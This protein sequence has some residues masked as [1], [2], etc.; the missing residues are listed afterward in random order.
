MWMLEGPS[1]IARAE[2]RTLAT[3]DH[4]IRHGAHLL[5]RD[6]AAFELPDAPR[7]VVGDA[8]Q[9]GLTP[10]GF[11][12][13]GQRAD[14]QQQLQQPVFDCGRTPQRAHG[15]TRV[16]ALVLERQPVERATRDLAV[17]T[18]LAA[19]YAQADAA[20]ELAIS[21]RTVS[22]T[23]W[24]SPASRSAMALPIPRLAPVTNATGIGRAR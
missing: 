7:H 3:S 4:A 2:L 6:L 23:S 1:V 13:L 24:P 14:R 15:G 11:Q 17:V 21:A 9:L 12:I 10:D 8:A 19:G 5:L 20:K 22:D 16:R 18:L